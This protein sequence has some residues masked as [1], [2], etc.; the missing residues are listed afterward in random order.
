MRKGYNNHHWHNKPPDRKWAGVWMTS[1]PEEMV[2]ML[3]SLDQLYKHIIHI[4]LHMHAEHND[5]KDVQHSLLEK[6]TSHFIWKYCVWEGVGDRTELQHTDPHSYGHQR[7]FSVLL[8]C[9][10]R[11]PGGPASLGHVPQSSI[12][13]P[14]G[15]ISKLLNRGPEGSLCWV[16]AFSTASCHQRVWSPN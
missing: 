7:F 8:G 1:C 5:N 10:T 2:L 4:H 15:L 3:Y 11:G 16:M 14:T 13:L 6:Y 9:S 12:F